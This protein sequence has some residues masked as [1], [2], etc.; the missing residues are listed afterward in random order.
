MTSLA[1]PEV[2]VFHAGALGDFVLTWPLLRALARAEGAGGRVSVIADAGKARLAAGEIGIAGV[3]GVGSERAEFTALWGGVVGRDELIGAV[4]GGR[5]RT[6]ITFGADPRMAAGRAWRDHLVG[7]IGLVE[8][9]FAG[10]P[11]SR[12]RAELWARAD[13]ALLGGVGARTPESARVLCHVGAGARA[14]MWGM[15]RWAE[16]V[17]GLRAGGREVGVIA[18]EVEFDRLSYEERC[19]FGEMGGET[20]WTLEELASA[21]KACA[22]FVGADTGPTHLAAQLGVRTVALFGPTDPGV[23]A[24]VGA[25]VEV[26]EPGGGVSGGGLRGMEWLGVGRVMD[27]VIGVGGD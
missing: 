14:K 26:I 25:R 5:P 27:V 7:S 13:V 9:V 19:V 2:W 12:S 1:G 17:A 16:L 10:A 3:R 8:V 20:L 21:T 6:V 24:P 18:G 23:W 22:V 4:G 11:G 15:E